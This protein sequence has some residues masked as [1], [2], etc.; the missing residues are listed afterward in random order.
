MQ[1]KPQPATTTAALIEE[2]ISSQLWM[3]GVSEFG[4]DS[5]P[6]S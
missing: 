4:I 6:I 1:I 5:E 3:L 2:K